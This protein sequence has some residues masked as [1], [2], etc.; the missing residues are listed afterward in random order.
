MRLLGMCYLCL[1]PRH[2]V[3]LCRR[4]AGYHVLEWSEDWKE[5]DAKFS[6][7][8]NLGALSDFHGGNDE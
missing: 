7:G 6:F 1:C 3:F 8:I 5:F 4:I 2:I